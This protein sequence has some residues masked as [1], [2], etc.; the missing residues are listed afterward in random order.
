[1]LTVKFRPILLYWF[2]ACPLRGEPSGATGFFDRWC[3]NPSESGLMWQKLEWNYWNSPECHQFLVHIKFRRMPWFEHVFRNLSHAQHGLVTVAMSM[4]V[5]AT[6]AVVVAPAI[7]KFENTN[8]TGCFKI[9]LLLSLTLATS[10]GYL[11][12]NSVPPPVDQA[13]T[14]ETTAHRNT[15]LSRLP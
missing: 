6:Q 5:Q 11:G 14:I 13:R 15:R 10:V 7:E 8:E 9:G 12:S 4:L 3:I 1:M 2:E